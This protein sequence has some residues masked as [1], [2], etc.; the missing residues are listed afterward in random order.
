VWHY[1]IPG[2]ALCYTAKV[3]SKEWDGLV[4]SEI[5]TMET[6]TNDGKWCSSL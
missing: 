4:H 3:F 2:G 6:V 1:S 5:T